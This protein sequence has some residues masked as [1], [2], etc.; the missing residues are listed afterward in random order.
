MSKGNLNEKS[1]NEVAI[2]V[3]IVI[4]GSMIYY[5]VFVEAEKERAEIA[6]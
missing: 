5:F 3:I 6:L 2:V 4:A 1:I